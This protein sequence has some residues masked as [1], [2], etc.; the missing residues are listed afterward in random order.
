MFFFVNK[1]QCNRKRDDTK[2]LIC[3]RV[4]RIEV[5]KIMLE[6]QGRKRET[7]TRRKMD[8][9][10]KGKNMRLHFNNN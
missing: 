10:F 6:R 3:K 5:L 9:K 4:Q 1:I 2:W 7:T 8:K